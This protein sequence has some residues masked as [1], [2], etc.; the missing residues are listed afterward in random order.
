[1]KKRIALIAMVMC[2]LAMLSALNVSASDTTNQETKLR[3]FVELC[4]LYA[5]RSVEY[6][7]FL[8]NKDYTITIIP[9]GEPIYFGDKAG[10]YCAAGWATI[11]KKDFT[12][13]E[14]RMRLIEN[15]IT[16]NKKNTRVDECILG[17]SALEYDSIADR[18]M[19]KD[20]RASGEKPGNAVEK[21]SMVFD[22]E[23]R[24]RLTK[25]LLKTLKDDSE[26]ILLYSGNY[27]YYASYS[28]DTLSDG[29]VEEILYLTAKE[30]AQ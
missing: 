22:E 24:S 29:S 20:Y 19:A 10:L 5:Y 25:D 17:I 6:R 26:E 27:D 7:D 3:C 21:A 11:Y 23:I 30:K 28:K 13:S 9:A 12:I 16:K 8:N 14:L 15:N 2:I 18:A 1:M 4:E